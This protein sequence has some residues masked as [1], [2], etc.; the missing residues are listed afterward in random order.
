ML[1]GIVHRRGVREVAMS[2]VLRGRLG[3]QPESTNIVVMGGR[4]TNCDPAVLMVVELK[5]VARRVDGSPRESNIESQVRRRRTWETSQ[6]TLT[7]PRDGRMEAAPA[8]P[9]GA[10]DTSV[11]ATLARPILIYLGRFSV[12][13][14]K[15]ASLRCA[16]NRAVHTLWCTW[17]QELLSS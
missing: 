17:G 9:V 3:A 14:C 16:S 13:V 11:S 2:R 12:R 5:H 4:H 10:S 6:F 7:S 8:E 15:Q 1:A